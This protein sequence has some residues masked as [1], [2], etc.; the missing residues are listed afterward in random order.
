MSKNQR[1][2]LES[3]MNELEDMG[4]NA[5]LIAIKPFPNK[6]MRIFVHR[7]TLLK[8]IEILVNNPQ[9]NLGDQNHI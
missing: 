8:I 5:D 7:S 4:F 2:K 3:L 1:S 6:E 9:L